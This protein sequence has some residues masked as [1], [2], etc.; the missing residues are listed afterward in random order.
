MSTVTIL[1]ITDKW[2]L[3]GRVTIPADNTDL[4]LSNTSMLYNLRYVITDSSELP[5][6]GVFTGVIIEPGKSV[7]MRL[8]LGEYLYVATEH[9]RHKMATLHM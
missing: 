3:G 2:S 9:M 6:T 5:S 8:M 7:G 4:L 1:N